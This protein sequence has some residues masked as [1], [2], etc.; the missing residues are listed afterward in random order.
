MRS[1]LLALLA[2]TTV[3][4]AQDPP[5]PPEPEAAGA[6]AA[7]GLTLDAGTLLI[8]GQTVNINLSKDRAGEPIS[9]APALWYGVDAK[10]TIG[11]TH[12]GGATWLSPRP[13]P[14]AG[15]CLTG[16]DGGCGEV[17]DN[18]G[19]DV[20]YGVLDGELALAIHGGLYVDGFD[21]FTL[22]LRA[23]ALGRFGITGEVSL[24]FDPAL[25]IGLTEREG[26]MGQPRNKEAISLPFWLWFQANAQLGIYGAIGLEGPL[27]DFGDNLAVPVGVGVTYAIDG[28]LSLGGDFW[29][30]DL[31]DDADARGASFRV[32]YAL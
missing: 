3:A 22:R 29:F 4:L 16:E 8:A 6:A 12:D 26:P 15:I 28:Q 13:V 5:P 20:L 10:L 21:P 11:V 25:F 31:D 18:V 23:G 30:L 19:A 24:V 17:Y 32:A 14:G 2:T 9:V 7:T 27:E 1:S